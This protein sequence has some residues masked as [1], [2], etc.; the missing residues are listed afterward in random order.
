MGNIISPDK[1]LR[2]FFGCRREVV[3]EIFTRD[4]LQGIAQKLDIAPGGAFNL[5]L[6]WLAPPDIILD[7]AEETVIIGRYRGIF[8]DI[9]SP[10]MALAVQA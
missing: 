5:G 3:S 10:S 7:L 9:R 1:A 2:G 8:T 4:R 6:T